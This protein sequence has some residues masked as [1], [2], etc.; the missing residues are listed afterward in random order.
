M[1]NAI[2]GL[3][4]RDSTSPYYPLFGNVVVVDGDIEVLL[5]LSKKDCTLELS[6]FSQWSRLLP[7]PQGASGQW[8]AS[9][10]LHFM[11]WEYQVRGG[12]CFCRG[13]TNI[14]RRSIS[15]VLK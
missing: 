12:V 4:I 6:A 3:L 10:V 14:D 9:S 1:S 2:E 13:K 5:L 8:V 7:Q 11:I 15:G